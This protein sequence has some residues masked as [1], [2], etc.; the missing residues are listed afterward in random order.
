MDWLNSH[1][2]AGD[3]IALVQLAQSERSYSQLLLM[4]PGVP[5]QFFLDFFFMVVITEMFFFLHFLKK[6]DLVVDL[7]LQ[8]CMKPLRMTPRRGVK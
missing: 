8:G 1:L 5:K 3:G 4:K 2:N 7:A 6:N